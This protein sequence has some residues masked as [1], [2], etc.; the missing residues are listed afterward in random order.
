M[1]VK[2]VLSNCVF[3]IFQLYDRRWKRGAGGLE[4]PQLLKIF[5]KYLFLPAKSHEKT[6]SNSQKVEKKCHEPPTSEFIPPPLNYT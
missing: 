6:V 1:R 5:R 2:D 4:P 3:E